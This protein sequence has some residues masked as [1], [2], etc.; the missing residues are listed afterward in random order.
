MDYS[1]YTQLKVEKQ[2]GIAIVTL[3]RPE[4]LNVV[5]AKM[6]TELV[7]IFGDLNQDNEVRA[8]VLTGAGRAFS[9]G[10]DMEWFKEIGAGGTE[11]TIRHVKEATMKEAKGIVNNLLDLEAPII[12]AINGYTLG[13]GATIALL[14]D[15]I[16]ASDK[17]KFGDPH[18][19]VGLVA[20]DGGAV[21]WPL[22]VGVAKAKELL[23]TGDSIDA[24]EAER[25][26]LVN[27]VVP[28]AELMPAAMGLAKRLADG[29]T[30]AIQW[31]KMAINKVVRERVNLILDT[32]LGW[33]QSTFV[34]EDHREAVKAFLEKRKP[35]FQRR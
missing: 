20:G 28:E 34:S 5:N 24:R 9:A 15:V 31:T 10:G 21:I 14:C 17:A 30:L 13:L 35:K 32:S 16:I 2:E 23:M 18:V 11:S 33:E 1:S 3:N 27:K 19:K 6:H 8:V 29:P 26:G 25:L 22:L 7:S 4:V 12:A